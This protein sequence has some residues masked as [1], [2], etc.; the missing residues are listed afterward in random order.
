MPAPAFVRGS[1]AAQSC[2]PSS[3]VAAPPVSPPVSPPVVPSPSPRRLL[4]RVAV[5][6][7]PRRV[8]LPSLFPFVVVTWFVVAL[9]L[10]NPFGPFL[11]FVPILR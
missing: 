5:P 6:V 11:L 8:F 4:P 2:R 10:S 3:V 7:S 9:L 1:V